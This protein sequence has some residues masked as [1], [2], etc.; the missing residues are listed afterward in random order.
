MRFGSPC[1]ILRSF[2]ETKARAHY[3]DWLGFK[4]DFEHRFEPGLPLYMGLSYGDCK[5]HLSEHHG[6]GAPGANIRIHCD[7][8]DAFCAELNAK[9][10]KYGRPGIVDQE[11]GTREMTTHDPF[12]NRLIFFCE[13]PKT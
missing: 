13:R 8:L 5:L 3:L 1:P 2:D 9:G 6:D 4:V 12:G 7:A 10:Y 11:W